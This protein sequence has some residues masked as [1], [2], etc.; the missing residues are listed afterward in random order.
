MRATL[1]IAALELRRRLRDRS[2]VVIAFV[3]P[4]ALAVV[5]SLAFGGDDGLHATVA[6]AGDDDPIA[7]AYRDQV[8][9]ALADEG[10]VAVRDA[11]DAGDAD[12]VDAAVAD[13]DADVGVVLPE[14]ASRAMTGVGH[15]LAI[16]VVRRADRTVA[17]DVVE[18][19][20]EEFVGE[21]EGLRAALADPEAVRGV[22]DAIGVAP[23]EL[24]QADPEALAAAVDQATAKGGLA[25]QDD[26]GRLG[27][28]A[29]LTVVAADAGNGLTAASYFGP[30]MALLFVMLTL[31]GVP[32]TLLAD[33]DGGQLARVRAAPVP[34]WSPTVGTSLAAGV[35]A[36]CSIAVVWLVSTLAFDATWGDPL[37]VAALSLVTV[38]AFGAIAALVAALARTSAQADGLG[39]IVAFTLGLLAGHFFQ[40]HQMPP[41]LR[42]IAL[43]TPNGWA[44]R[45]FT[46]LSADG[47]GLV[48]ILPALGA[49][50]GLG[51]LITVLA[52]ALLRLRPA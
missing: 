14:Q 15:P 10:V 51:V 12:A 35:L 19:A 37:A 31:S 45:A 3:A 23:D 49:I 40:L 29:P 11:G 38:A 39:M 8:L 18:A 22:A 41:L 28:S 44:L 2:A 24:A 27:A 21:V 5:I 26:R 50:A 48:D 46:D 6:L 47:A 13:G 33:R 7:T 17:G 36:L 43:A 52:A 16:K 42:H 32:K 1:I 20:T 30:S 34:A 25:A 9:G 4:V